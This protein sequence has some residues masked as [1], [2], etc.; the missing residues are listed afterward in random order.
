MD[1]PVARTVA[2]YES[3]PDAFDYLAEE[4]VYDWKGQSFRE[5]LSGPRVL[6]VG[7]GPGADLDAMV[8][9]DLTPVGL[10]RTGRFL[11]DVRGRVPAASTVRGDMRA[12]PLADGS[13]DGVWCCA[14]LLH[15]PRAAIPGTL[16]EFARV[17]RSG[18]PLYVSVVAGTGTEFRRGGHGAG[19]FFTFFEASEL[20]GLL[21]DAG[22]GVRA[23]L[24]DGEWVSLVATRPD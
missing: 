18:G 23:D 4:S 24:S 21:S 19:R 8:G 13:V 10:D 7:C 12:L 3:H 20:R 11:A 5:R 16:A 6:D 9:D 14:A 15:L 2:T 17:T 22:Y 1:D